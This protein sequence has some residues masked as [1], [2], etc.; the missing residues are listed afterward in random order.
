MT[1]GSA[2]KFGFTRDRQSAFGQ[3]H[4]VARPKDDDHFQELVELSR[5]LDRLEQQMAEEE[6]EIEGR[7]AKVTSFKIDE[8]QTRLCAVVAGLCRNQQNVFRTEVTEHE[9]DRHRE[10]FVNQPLERRSQFWVSLGHVAIERIEPQFVKN[11]AVAESLAQIGVAD[12]LSMN[13]REHAAEPAGNQRIDFAFEQ[14]LLP[15]EMLARD[16]FHREQIVI[17]VL[18]QQLRNES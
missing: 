4:A 3:G 15:N 18:E 7:I 2:L 11:R 9:A 5:V 17:A 14:T 6:S 12:R 1:N 10:R 16:R 13:G 8:Y